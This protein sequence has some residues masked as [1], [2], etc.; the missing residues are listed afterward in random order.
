MTASEEASLFFET[1]AQ[2]KKW[3]A[4]HHATSAGVWLRLAKKDSSERSVSYAEAV[5]EALCQGWIDGRKKADDDSFWLQRFTPRSARSVWSKI[6]R[7]KAMTLVKEKRMRPAGKAQIDRA[8]KDG[9]WEAA[10]DGART[11]A[12]PP[13][14]KAALDADRHAAAFFETLDAANRY[15]I[16][17]RLQTAKKAETR[18]RRLAQFVAML[19]RHEKIHA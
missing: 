16:L 11:S 12:I 10:Y 4:T 6:N 7:D 18:E 5:E 17:W 14:L 1:A 9:R 19:A 8:K 3:L 15:A 2:W 13:D